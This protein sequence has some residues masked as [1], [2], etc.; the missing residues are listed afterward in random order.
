MMRKDRVGSVRPFV[1][2]KRTPGQSKQSEPILAPSKHSEQ[3]PSQSRHWG[4]TPDRSSSWEWD[5]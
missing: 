4:R 1:H 5:A 2:S 3:M